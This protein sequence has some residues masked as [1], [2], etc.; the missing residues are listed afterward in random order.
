MH[1]IAYKE[2]KKVLYINDNKEFVTLTVNDSSETGF[3][4]ITLDTTL[5]HPAYNRLGEIPALD[6]EGNVVDIDME[7]TTIEIPEGD[8]VIVTAFNLNLDG[9][10]AFTHKHMIHLIK[11]QVHIPVQ[12]YCSFNFLRFNMITLCK[13]T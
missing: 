1:C 2:N 5:E 6:E 4:I 13:N 9:T 3:T 11:Q 10:T 12:K 7:T 8:D